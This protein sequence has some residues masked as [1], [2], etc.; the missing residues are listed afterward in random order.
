MRVVLY[1]QLLT[2]DAMLSGGSPLSAH[3][4]FTG[5]DQKASVQSLMAEGQGNLST[6]S[7]MTSTQQVTLSLLMSTQQV[8]LSLLTSTQEVHSLLLTVRLICIIASLSH[9]QLP[10]QCVKHTK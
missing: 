8:T 10:S 3:K 6:L 4:L 7:L 2:T 1:Q 9:D 5:D